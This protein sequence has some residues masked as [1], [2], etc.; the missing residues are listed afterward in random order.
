MNSSTEN[1]E[2]QP[3]SDTALNAASSELVHSLLRLLHIAQYRRKTIVQAVCVA[4]ILGATYYA[5]APRYY[6]SNAKLLIVHRNQ[7]QIASMADPPSVDS[8]M[9]THREIV[10]SPVVLQQA[11]EQ[12]LPEQ[13][14]DFQDAPPS[15][16]ARI[17]AEGLSARTTRKANFIEV[18]YRSR[19]PE[20]AAA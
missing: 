18:S 16:W 8:T 17:L 1:S 3:L 14:V 4:A 2:L 13:R 6:D 12:L 5:L 11:V 20:A 19:S 7:D 10:V 9:A 15:N